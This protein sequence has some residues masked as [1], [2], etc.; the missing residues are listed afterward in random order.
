MLLLDTNVVS[1]LRRPNRRPLV[2]RWAAQH[3]IRELYLS[4][5]SIG[6]IRRGI[7]RQERRDAPFAHA[8]NGWLSR[9]LALYGDCILPLH[10]PVAQCRGH[11][12]AT[13]GYDS[14]DLLIAATARVHGLTAVTRNVRHFDRTGESVLNPFEPEGDM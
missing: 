10:V 13:L 12:S 14:V 4:G 9:L 7:T 8:L 3:Q 1:A 11:L 5:V 2:S 6:E